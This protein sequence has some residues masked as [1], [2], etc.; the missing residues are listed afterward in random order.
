[1]M[2]LEIKTK[3]PYKIKKKEK[4]VL[5]SCPALDV[6][7][8]GEN[9]D[10]ATKNLGEAIHL[11]LVTCFEK[12]TL[13]EVLKNCGFKPGLRAKRTK[14]TLERKGKTI[15]VPIPFYFDKTRQRECPA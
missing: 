5:A 8:Q 7:S 13:D 11:F 12:G 10:Q 1:M 9:E 2:T 15:D 6:H 3:L 14:R 4:W